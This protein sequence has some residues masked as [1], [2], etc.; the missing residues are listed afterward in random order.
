M[1]AE[2]GNS[3]GFSRILGRHRG[4]EP[5]ATLLCVAGVHGNEPGGVLALQRV[6]EQLRRLC[7]AFAG[8]LVGL[9]GN[10]TAL[11]RGRRYVD[12]D[13]NRM[14]LGDRIEARFD[15]FP[16]DRDAVRERAAQ[17]AMALLLELLG[18]FE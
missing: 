9:T 3:P 10:L 15:R 14:W 5:G 7:P 12:T 13:L 17:A 1:T 8:E 16:G 11:A 18:G 4:D 2:I 6:F